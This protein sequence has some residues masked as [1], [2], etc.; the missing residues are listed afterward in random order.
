ML[1]QESELELSIDAR[2]EQRNSNWAYKLRDLQQKSLVKAQ[3]E[4][5]Y[6]IQDFKLNKRSFA[7]DDFLCSTLLSKSES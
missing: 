4:C 3:I 7:Q 5:Y 6:L 1:N 2:I